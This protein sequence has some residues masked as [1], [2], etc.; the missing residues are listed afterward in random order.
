MKNCFRKAGF[1]KNNIGNDESFWTTNA[2][3]SLSMPAQF[4]NTIK[5]VQSQIQVNVEH[6]INLDN[7]IIIKDEVVKSISTEILIASQE[8]IE[9]KKNRN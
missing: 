6:Y 1:R 8:T 5:R 3:L 2:E 4:S 9:R 7:D